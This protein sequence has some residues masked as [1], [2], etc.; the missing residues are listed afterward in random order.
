MAF[1]TRA[2]YSAPSTAAAAHED[3]SLQP[4]P[5]L[6]RGP[7]LHLRR[8]RLARDDLGR[9]RLGAA[10]AGVSGFQTF[11]QCAS[12]VGEAGTTYASSREGYQYMR[13]DGAGGARGEPA[14]RAAR[15][16]GLVLCAQ[17]VL[18]LR[19]LILP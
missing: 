16:T 8:A 13:I 7:R 12:L 2:R 15:G 9:R 4:R 14:V 10:D 6:A 11:Y 17:S 5:V 19:F 18:S 1:A 3:R